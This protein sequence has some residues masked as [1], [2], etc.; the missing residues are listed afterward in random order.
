MADVLAIVSK[1]VFE[2]GSPGATLGMVVPFER[3]AS[4]H[5]TLEA[6][7]GGGSLF[8]V[9]VRPPDER[10]WLVAVL[11]A[12]DRRGDGWY[13]RNTTPITDVTAL[14][15]ALRFASGKGI[16]AAPGALGMSLQT[17][18]IL[19]EEDAQRLRGAA[20]APGSSS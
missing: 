15:P 9:T 19:T 17:P 6:L 13:A 8:L 4:T 3:Y 20:A 5:A 12:P 1:A 10:L 16:Q 14:R 7:A 18:R 11:E 2:R